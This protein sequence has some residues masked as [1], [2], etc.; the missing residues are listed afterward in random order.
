LISEPPV[1]REQVARDQHLTAR[2]VDVGIDGKV[3]FVGELGAALQHLGRA[4]LRREW[5]DRPVQRAA[6][7]MA[8]ELVLE[9]VELLADRPRLVS[10]HFLH[11]GRQAVPVADHADRR[12]VPD[13]GRE[14]D[15]N[16]RLAIGGNN[17]IGLL[18]GERNKPQHV[19]HG[20]DAAPQALQRAH[21]GA[22]T[23]LLLAA[24][25]PHRQR[26]EQPYFQRQLLEQAATEH[27]MG[28]VVRVDES[29]HDQ[30][31]GRIDDLVH[32]VEGKIATDRKYPVVLDQDVGDR[33]LMDIT[34]VVVHLTA[35]D[36]RALRCHL[37]RSSDRL[38]RSKQPAR[39]ADEPRRRIALGADWTKEKPLS[40][41]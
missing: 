35:A 40:K 13:H 26:V 18:I 19:L 4:A 11:R 9:I 41:A 20:G 21:Q 3:V 34:L 24:I 14:H 15:A 23:Y 32:A 8:F 38:Q 5:R 7:R 37:P 27:V 16:P 39:A 25:G 22:R 1:V 10:Q 12:D 6:G 28:M 17:D 29:G 31:S 30:A 33:R 2:L 36:Q